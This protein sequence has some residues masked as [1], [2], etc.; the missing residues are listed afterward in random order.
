MTQSYRGFSSGEVS[1]LPVCTSVRRAYRFFIPCERITSADTER[2]SYKNECGAGAAQ[3]RR[4][5]Q[6]RGQLPTVRMGNSS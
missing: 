6:Q 4:T 5:P 1:Q 2:R 3:S